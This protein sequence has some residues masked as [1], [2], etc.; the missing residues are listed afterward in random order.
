VLLKSKRRNRRSEKFP[1]RRVQDARCGRNPRPT[2]SD[3][4]DAGGGW[5]A[6]KANRVNV[7]FR[8]SG[9][10]DLNPFPPFSGTRLPAYSGG[11]V[12]R[13][14]V[15]M[16]SELGV[17]NGPKRTNAAR[18]VSFVLCDLVCSL[19]TRC[20]SYSA[21][22]PK[23]VSSNLLRHCPGTRNNMSCNPTNRA[24]DLS[25]EPRASTPL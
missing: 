12:S 11:L 4:E 23:V 7:I 3:F 13:P 24:V 1:N 6:S 25:P 2:A 22:N 16:L 8:E 20:A 15:R 5:E 18:P 19:C 9:A 17:Q 10:G 21:H 14:T